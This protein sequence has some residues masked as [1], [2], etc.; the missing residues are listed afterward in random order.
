MLGVSVNDLLGIAEQFTAAVNEFRDNPAG[1]IQQLSQKI[2]E[3]LGLP[4]FPDDGNVAAAAFLANLGLTGITPASLPAKFQLIRFAL[5]G[6]ILKF[7][8]RL[9]LGFSEALNVDLDLGEA[10]GVDLGPIDIQGGAGLAASGYLD[11]RL[12]FGIDLT[13]PA[14]LVIY[15][16]VTGVFG[17]LHAGGSNLQFNAAIGPL[18]AFVRTAARTSTSTSP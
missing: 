18:G 4:S 11:A 15:D 8:L 1:G 3:A 17:G 5:D 7:D 12:S 9:P 10:L 6:N 16:D 14:L 2:L 13:N